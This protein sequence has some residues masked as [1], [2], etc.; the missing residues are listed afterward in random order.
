M[1]WTRD[2]TLFC[3]GETLASTGPLPHGPSVHFS[4]RSCAEKSNQPMGLDFITALI[5]AAAAEHG[6]A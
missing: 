2:I 6:H 4:S 3:E 1:S 5:L